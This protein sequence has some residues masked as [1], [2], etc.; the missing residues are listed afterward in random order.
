MATVE[1]KLSRSPVS[2]ASVG[3][4]KLIRGDTPAVATFAF[5]IG[6]SDLEELLLVESLEPPALNKIGGGSVDYA[7]LSLMLPDDALHCGDGELIALRGQYPG[8]LLALSRAAISI[9]SQGEALQSA[10]VGAVDSSLV[11]GIDGIHGS[12]LYGKRILRNCRK[13][14]SG[15]LAQ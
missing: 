11:L 4:G 10:P 1:A 7:A 13:I 5:R 8:S 3:E 2:G 9:V 12:M 14:F 6:S 15:D